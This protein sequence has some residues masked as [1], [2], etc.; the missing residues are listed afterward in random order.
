MTKENSL[1]TT[2]HEAKSL[3]ITG[4]SLIAA[5]GGLLFGYDTGVMTGVIFILQDD[6]NWLLKGSHLGLMVAIALLGCAI[7]ALIGGRLADQRG[8]RFAL[9]L[10][11]VLFIVGSIACAFA[12]DYWFL[13]GSRLLVGAA[14]GV[15]SVATPLYISELAPAHIRGRLV[16]LYQFAIVI[17]ILAA[18]LVSWGLEVL[19]W[20]TTDESWRWMFGLGAVPAVILLLGIPWLPASPRWLVH[21]G[22]IDRARKVLERIL[23]HPNHA[24]E[25]ID[26]VQLS[27]NKEDGAGGLKTV[28]GSKFRMALIVGLGLA[29]FQQLIGINAVLY[30]GDLIFK[31]AGFDEA[32][33]AFQNEVIVGTVNAL[34]TLIAIWLLDKV[35]RVPLMLIGLIGMGLSMAALSLT[36]LS[37]NDG[38]D[39]TALSGWVSLIAMCCYVACFAFSMGPIVWVM[40]AEIFPLKVRGLAIAV[41]TAANWIANLAVSYTFPILKDDLSGGWTFMIY[42]IMI[43]L[44]FIF[45]I[46][47][48]PETKGK[49]LEELEEIWH[50]NKKD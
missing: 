34:F 33:G 27:I 14:I 38:A 16:S 44:T 3:L 29:I 45:I 43:I 6:P 40:I 30:Y 35:G 47:W 41:A 12:Q 22:H 48:V 10:S 36:F 39:T 25:A 20:V 13:F 26:L 9:F 19:P 46:V 17:G 28:F 15:T 49:T 18:F 11:G 7:G 42:V 1:E 24:R 50:Q 31:D 21:K 32:A 37:T 8:R 4:I 5:M 23:H 2:H